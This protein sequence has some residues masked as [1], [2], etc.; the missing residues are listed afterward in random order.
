MRRRILALCLAVL[1]VSVLADDAAGTPA[2]K[3]VTTKPPESKPKKL[4][5]FKE[6]GDEL[7]KVGKNIGKGTVDA[8]K[9]GSDKVSSDV[10]NKKLKPKPT[11]EAQPPRS[12]RTGTP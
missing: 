7:G 9:S 5:S 8:A 10:K 11:P 3:A 4:G 2:D 12:D 6:F 1:P